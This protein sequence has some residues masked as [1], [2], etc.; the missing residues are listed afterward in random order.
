MS[1]MLI[2]FLNVS[3]LKFVLIAKMRVCCLK[4]T[5]FKNIDV[6]LGFMAE[7]ESKKKENVSDENKEK[8]LFESLNRLEEE[9]KQVYG[10][11]SKL[12]EE[13]MMLREM[14]NNA[15][16]ELTNFR[17]PALLVADVVQVKGDKEIISKT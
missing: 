10:T 3:F 13:S 15:N 16:S 8:V 5:T 17:K 9:N 14:F 1:G 11:L 4:S 6:F 12:Q 7:E 2:V